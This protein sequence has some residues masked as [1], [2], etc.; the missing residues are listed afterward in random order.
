M[1]LFLKRE[2]ETNGKTNPFFFLFWFFHLNFGVVLKCF[3]LRLIATMKFGFGF[4]SFIR[5]LPPNP[6]FL[7]LTIHIVLLV[8]FFIPLFCFYGISW[9]SGKGHVDEDTLF[10]MKSK[11]PSPSFFH[12]PFFF[13]SAHEFIMGCEMCVFF[14]S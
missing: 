10:W 7:C 6:C 8:C 12:F 4:L 5:F 9:V 11:F 2:K 13:S 14:F 1:K 3:L